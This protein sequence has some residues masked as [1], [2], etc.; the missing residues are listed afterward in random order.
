M[1]TPSYFEHNFSL[2][3]GN[4]YSKILEVAYY[5]GPTVEHKCVIDPTSDSFALITGA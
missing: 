3:F 4:Q 2:D 5:T 1:R